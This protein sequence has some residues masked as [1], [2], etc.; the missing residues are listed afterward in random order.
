DDP[1]F[2]K[3]GQVY[4]TTTYPE[5]V[6]A[7]HYHKFQTD[8]FCAIK[9]TVKVALYDRRDN[10]PTK[11]VINELCLSEHSPGL[12]RIPAGVVHGW[13][14]ISQ[15]E[16]YI[17]NIPSEVYNYEKPDEFRIDPHDND[18]PYVWKRKDG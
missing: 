4:F 7:W 14:C 18:I 17:V 15:D 2:E 5:V 8:H 16:A 10:S 1:W 11:G 12:L 6:K 9:G 13:M 3:F